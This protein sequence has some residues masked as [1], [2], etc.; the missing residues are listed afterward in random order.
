MFKFRK[1][2]AQMSS[3]AISIDCVFKETKPVTE[4][5][6]LSKNWISTG[7]KY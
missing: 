6:D 5:S 4:K 2:T 7:E 3:L 1:I